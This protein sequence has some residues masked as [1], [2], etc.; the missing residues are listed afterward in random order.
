MRQNQS[1]GGLGV[2]EPRYSHS[3]KSN[4]LPDPAHPEYANARLLLD[5][6]VVISPDTKVL[7]GKMTVSTG[8]PQSFKWVK[9]QLQRKDVDRNDA[10]YRV[11]A[12]ANV[13]G[14]ALDP[15]KAVRIAIE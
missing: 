4:E 9:V 8:Q 10:R 14:V 13:E 3:L 6:P 11:Q 5:I 1:F 2:N 15:S 7:Y 12:R